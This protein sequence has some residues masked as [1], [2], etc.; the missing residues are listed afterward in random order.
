MRSGQHHRLDF[1]WQRAL[2]ATQCTSPQA[3]LLL[4][5]GV[6]KPTAMPYP[7]LLCHTTPCCPAAGAVREVPRVLCAAVCR[8]GGP[9]PAAAGR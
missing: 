8:P 4:L 1:Q 5:A 2:Q 3:R 9:G 6:P 7:T